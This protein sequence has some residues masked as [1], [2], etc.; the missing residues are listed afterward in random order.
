MTSLDG[1]TL[2]HLTCSFRSIHSQTGVRKWLSWLGHCDP[3]DR[4]T[5]PVNT[6][7][8]SCA[9]INF[10]AVYNLWSYQKSVPIIPC[11]FGVG[12]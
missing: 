2:Q 9:A 10:L 6:T 3:G 4:G 7:T 8:F 12:G 11:L 5:N 1:A